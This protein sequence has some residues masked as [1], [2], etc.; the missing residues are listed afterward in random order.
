MRHSF[1]KGPFSLEY[2]AQVVYTSNDLT[3]NINNFL[4]PPVFVKHATSGERVYICVMHPRK[5]QPNIKVEQQEI[6]FKSNPLH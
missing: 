1:P 5:R 2:Q 4:P 3:I 6:L